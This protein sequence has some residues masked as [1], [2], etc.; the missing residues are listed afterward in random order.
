MSTPVLLDASAAAREVATFA[1]LALLASDGDP[2]AALAI[3][4]LGHKVAPGH[5]GELDCA[6]I[7]AQ[8]IRD[9]VALRAG[10][11]GA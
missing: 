5:E 2:D 6:T 3:C 4:A 10:E 11:R 1:A 8:A 7:A 9:A